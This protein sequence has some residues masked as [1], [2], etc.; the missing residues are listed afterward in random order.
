MSG[1]F[2]NNPF[3]TLIYFHSIRV[4]IQFLKRHKL[5]T[6]SLKDISKTSYT[7]P[8]NSFMFNGCVFLNSQSALH[9]MR[10]RISFCVLKSETLNKCRMQLSV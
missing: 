8:L 7:R 9:K 2:V 6:E 5:S 3:Y 4:V 10:M 1:G